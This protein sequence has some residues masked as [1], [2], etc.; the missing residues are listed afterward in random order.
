MDL[1][2][3]IVLLSTVGAVL[4][5]VNQ[6]LI[7]Q[8]RRIG[9]VGSL[10]GALLYTYVN[11]RTGAYGYVGLGCFYFLNAALALYQWAP[12]PHK[13]EREAWKSSSRPS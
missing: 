9:W 10:V 12:S 5:I 4:A 6:T 3:T 7:R 11:W 1:P 8:Q 13:K 2:D